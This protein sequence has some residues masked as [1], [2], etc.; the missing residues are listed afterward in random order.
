MT[1]VD[2]PNRA[3][4]ERREQIGAEPRPTTLSGA[5]LA[6]EVSAARDADDLYRLYRPEWVIVY[7]ADALAVAP[8]AKEPLAP[9]ELVR[10]AHEHFELRYAGRVRPED[11][12]FTPAGVG[13]HARVHLELRLP[14]LKGEFK[15]EALARGY[16]VRM[17]W[18]NFQLVVRNSKLDH[19]LRAYGVKRLP[20]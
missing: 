6:A 19:E 5:D 4:V 7:T 13:P 16:A 18:S 15:F 14:N 3:I 20:K 2:E 11:V 9:D 10:Y 8:G 1:T 17:G 12:R